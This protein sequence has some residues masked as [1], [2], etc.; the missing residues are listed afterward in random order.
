MAVVNGQSQYQLDREGLELGHQQ[1]GII[2]S[3]NR[4]SLPPSPPPP[5][6]L[7]TPSGSPPP[8]SGSPPPSIPPSDDDDSEKNADEI[9]LDDRDKEYSSESS[10]TNSSGF[11]TPTAAEH[12]TSNGPVLVSQS[13][14]SLSHTSMPAPPRRS[15]STGI[16]NYPAENSRS[17]ATSLPGGGACGDLLE[18][19]LHSAFCSSSSLNVKFAPLPQLAPRRRK[20]NVPLGVAARGQI[21]RKRRQMMMNGDY[22]YRGPVQVQPNLYGDIVEA[23]ENELAAAQ[24]RA[25]HPGGYGVDEDGEEMEDPFVAI[26]RMFKGAWKKMRDKGKNGKEKEVP[27][28]DEGRE[29][30]DVLGG[31]KGSLAI[32]EAPSLP[33]QPA[34]PANTDSRSDAQQNEVGEETPVTGEATTPNELTALNTT[35]DTN[36]TPR[37]QDP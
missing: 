2:I 33:V 21:M 5:L 29:D 11:M 27:G 31:E 13:Q 23:E 35:P 1:D 16:L 8:P 26:G 7:V 37:R 6:P 4:K 30:E 18:E 17:R 15:K 28:N 32:E 22:Q 9:C 12:H 19:H 20:S 34:T 24:A 3:V 25:R 14:Q 10:S 36:T